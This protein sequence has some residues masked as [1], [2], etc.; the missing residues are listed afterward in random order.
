M[1]ELVPNL[2]DPQR[3][4]GQVQ[5]P[6]RQPGGQQADP[7]PATQTV[8]TYE[9]GR[10]PGT[11]TQQVIKKYDKDD[12]F[13]LTREECGFDDLTFA[14]LDTRRQRQARRRGTRRVADRPADLEVSLSLAPKAADCVGEARSPTRTTVAAAGSRSSRSNP[15]G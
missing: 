9:P 6:V 10:I 3:L 14:R 4:R 15:V 12:D 1:A 5:C 11:L 2:N 13:E 7:S 8:A